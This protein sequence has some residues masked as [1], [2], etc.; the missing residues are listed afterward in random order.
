MKW[1]IRIAG[2]LFLLLLLAVSA[3]WLIG[4]RARAGQ[5]RAAAEINGSPEQV[6][7]WL[8]EGEKLKQWVS[9]LVEVRGWNPAAGVGARRV[10]V[11]KDENN[12]G[13]L[14]EIQGVCS[15]YAPPTRLAV[16]LTVDGA[17]QGEQTY[18]L[19][20]LGNG[21]TRIEMDSAYRFASPLARLMEPLITA[22]AEK[23]AVA[24]I[25]QLKTLVSHQATAAAR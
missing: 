3:L 12:G 18:R 4:H 6:W 10:L 21:R 14:M 13:M 17:F 22:A 24:D 20:G 23:K 16:K 1:A 2:V 5:F 7:P 8:N 25:A 19:T 11:M 15:D 9:W